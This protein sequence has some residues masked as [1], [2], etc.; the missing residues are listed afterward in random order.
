MGDYTLRDFATAILTHRP[1]SV[2]QAPPRLLPSEHRSIAR[3]ALR[4]GLDALAHPADLAIGEGFR[5]FRADLPRRCGMHVDGD[6]YIPR[7]APT[8]MEALLIIHERSHGWSVRRRED[9]NEADAWWITVHLALPE[10]RLGEVNPH[11]S[12]WF[13]ALCEEAHDSITFVMLSA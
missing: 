7:W 8:D 4:H 2:G 10:M 3:S 5:L 12:A 9:A 6:I 11:I 1:Q 13:Q